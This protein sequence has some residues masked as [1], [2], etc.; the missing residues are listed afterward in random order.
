MV[1]RV[2]DI[3]SNAVKAA[4]FE[5]EERAQRLLG[6]DKLRLA[7]GDYAFQQGTL[8]DAALDRVAAFLRGLNDAWNG[9]KVH[10][11]FVVATA[12]MRAAKNREAALKR[13]EE[14]SGLPVRVLTG[15]EESF[16]VHMGVAQDAK[17]G[18]QE[19]LQSLD[20]GGGS[21]EMSWS[22][23]LEYIEGR[24]YELGA[25]RLAQKFVNGK[26]FS[27]ET[28]ERM[29]EEALAQFRKSAG[30]PRAD[31]VVGSSGNIRAVRHMVDGLHSLE[32]TKSVPEITRGSLED[33][34]EM[35]VGRSHQALPDVFELS[36]E[37]ARIIMPAVAC[38]LAS[39]RHFG[40][41]RISASEAGLRD[42]VAFFWSRNGHLH[43]PLPSPAGAA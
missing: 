31:R 32:F 18:P 25:I 12:A 15:A 37:R 8:P 13:L 39:M 35:A 40:I 42:G 16:L 20:L 14:K 38:L 43:I 3:G 36:P 10:F 23:G 7:L 34:M 27:R 11:T 21:F 19:V 24:S 2:V 28:F 9:E 17:A 4:W 30:G 41:T 33:V 22:R 29:Q 6:R 1:I 5:V 26:P